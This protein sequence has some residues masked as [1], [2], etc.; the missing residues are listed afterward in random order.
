M[1]IKPE[2]SCFPCHL[3][4]R[5]LDRC[6]IF[7]NLCMLFFISISL[8][9]CTSI[10]GPGKTGRGAS[11]TA[12]KP[13]YIVS[14]TEQEH[15]NGIVD[16][17]WSPD[18][19]WIASAAEDGTFDVW[20]PSTGA[21]VLQFSGGRT[22][23]SGEQFAIAWSP[24][25]T[26]LAATGP[27]RMF[28]VWDVRTRTLL[29][30]G[31]PDTVYG[32]NDVRGMSWSPDGTRLAVD[33]PDK[34]LHVWDLA[35]G[36]LL[37]SYPTSNK[38]L[39]AVWSPDSSRLVSE[40]VVNQDDSNLYSTVHVWNVQTG[41]QVLTY[42]SAEPVDDI[43]WIP[44]TNDVIA[45]MGDTSGQSVAIWNASS[46][47]TLSSM[48][49]AELATVSVACSSDGKLVA[50]SSSYQGTWTLTLWNTQ[51]GH[52]I[53][54]TSS[55]IT[56]YNLDLDLL[57]S[58]DNTRLAVITGDD[59]N[60]Q[61]SIWDTQAHTHLYDY[62]TTAP[63]N[64][65]GGLGSID[66]LAWSPDGQW[67]AFGDNRD[68]SARIVLFTTATPLRVYTYVDTNNPRRWN[69]VL[70]KW[71]PDGRHIVSSIGTDAIQV[72]PTP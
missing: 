43:A 4:E 25:S 72:W 56:R 22:P 37:L 46:G 70:L 26:S 55:A 59:E 54:Q 38:V 23:Q 11:I 71:S 17:A 52:T 3:K 31:S 60:R 42:Y 65:G 36:D 33:G 12:W 15:G 20:N 48:H 61:I 34:T 40:E 2:H 51:T 5:R 13:Q 44:H 66:N 50:I 16:I 53:F 18:G 1:T 45:T 63:Q 49:Y 62:L 10:P 69:G 64:G 9:T 19:K 68:T 27:G 47:Q 29:L 32:D 24:D 39:K 28:Q 41:K 14:Y 57:W 67:I 35:T 58:P 21:P 30:H 8:V 7:L 6:Q